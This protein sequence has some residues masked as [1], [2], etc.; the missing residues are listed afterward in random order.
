MST[1]AAHQS[2]LVSK[3]DHIIN[4]SG[5]PKAKWKIGTAPMQELILLQVKEEMHYLILL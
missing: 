4:Q 2:D 1:I 3:I 5:L